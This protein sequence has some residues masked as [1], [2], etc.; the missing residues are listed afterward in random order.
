LTS[1][2]PALHVA[3]ERGNVTRLGH[4]LAQASGGP[5]LAPATA[6]GA[7]RGQRE[8]AAVL[9]LAQ[10]LDTAGGLRA[11]AGIDKAEVQARGPHQRRAV[12]VGAVGQQPADDLD[13]FRSC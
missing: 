8:V 10:R 4:G 12:G 5:D 1:A 6:S 9:K 11:A 3:G 13:R 7:G 2:R